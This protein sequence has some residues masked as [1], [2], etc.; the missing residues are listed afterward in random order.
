MYQSEKNDKIEKLE[1]TI[2]G[3]N[4]KYPIERIAIVFTNQSVV[5]QPKSDEEDLNWAI[6]A[7]KVIISKKL[8]E[9][10]VIEA[11]PDPVI[12]QPVIE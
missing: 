3:L 7:L 4:S 8:D 5:Y 12:E 6:D 1:S 2:K 11:E 9:V 10:K